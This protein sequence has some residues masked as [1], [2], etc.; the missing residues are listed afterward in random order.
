[1]SKKVI[2]VSSYQGKIDWK[3]AKESG[4]D[5]AILKIIRKDL[6]PDTQFENN[7]NGC[8][9]ANL[10]VIGV[11]NYSYATTVAKAKKDAETVVKTLGN[12]KTKVWL[13][14]E[15][16]CQTKLGRTLIDIINEYG[17]VITSHS[18]EFG[19]YTGKDFY[20]SYIKKYGGVSH[21]L[22]IARYGINNGLV[23]AKYQPQ[24]N[25]MDG[26]QY[27]SK[28]KVNGI[29]GFVDMSLWYREVTHF[30]VDAKASNPHFNPY[31]E[32][33]VLLY[34]KTPMMRGNE[35]R[36]LQYELIHHKVLVDKNGKGQSNI[37]GVFG[38]DTLAAVKAFQKKSGIKEDGIVG[39]V[40]RK[41]LK[42]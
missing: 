35:V 10:P 37:D 42:M 15:D 14:V 39:V 6:K 31:D 1:M 12:R 38:D 25:N 2:D 5:G 23:N 3:K 29:S 34:R 28:A 20:N 32:P 33:S 30:A 11:Y 21:S 27:T 41:Y 18:L 7:W 22:W 9:N 17:K 4:V 13:D 24:F 16:S 36:W 26:W 8:K 40:T 19:V